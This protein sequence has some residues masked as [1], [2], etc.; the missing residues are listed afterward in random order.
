MSVAMLVGG[1]WL[2]AAELLWAEKW[3]GWAVLG[4][5]MLVTLGAYLLWADFIAPAFGL[6]TEHEPPSSCYGLAAVIVYPS[7]LRLSSLPPVPMVE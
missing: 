3:Y 6:K 4:G 2:L 5:A 1:L 7:R